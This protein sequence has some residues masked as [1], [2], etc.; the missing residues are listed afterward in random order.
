MK[1]PLPRRPERWASGPT[2]DAVLRLEIPADLH[3]EREFEI[4]VAMSVRALDGAAAPWHELRI[5][6]NGQLEWSRR[7]PTATD[8]PYDGLDMRFRRR[9]EA[10]RRLSLLAEVNCGGARR[11]KLV[12]EAEE[13]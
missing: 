4:S 8:Q 10:Q 13:A 5:F 6:A 7:I 9:V 12:I 1:S 3:R 2:A 11:L